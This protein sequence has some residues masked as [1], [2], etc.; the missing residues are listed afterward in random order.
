[1]TPYI[2][3]GISLKPPTIY[4]EKEYI[5]RRVASYFNM[6]SDTLR[7]KTRLRKVV[8]ARQFAQYFLHVNYGYT[9]QEIGTYYGQD[10]TTVAHSRKTIEALVVY[11]RKAYI[12][13]INLVNRLYKK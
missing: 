11:N 8:Y 3:P 6:K 4:I 7:K 5:N 2:Y 1:M 13:F 12:D 9:C 10:H